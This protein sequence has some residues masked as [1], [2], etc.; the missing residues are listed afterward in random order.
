MSSF[1]VEQGGVSI[2]DLVVAEFR[3]GCGQMDLAPAYV[4][5]P[6]NCLVLGFVAWIRGLVNKRRSGGIPDWRCQRGLVGSEG[7][8]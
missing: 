3:R 5:R 4:L 2:P 7:G 1:D 6:L 8:N